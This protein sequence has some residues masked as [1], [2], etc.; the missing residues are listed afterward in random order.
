[1]GPLILRIQK[2]II[3]YLILKKEKNDIKIA[4]EKNDCAVQF[5]S[6]YAQESYISEALT[7]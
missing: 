6:K 7:T 3:Q 4:S 5:S 2:L 1:M